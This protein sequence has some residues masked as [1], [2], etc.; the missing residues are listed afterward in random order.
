MFQ[1]P[2]SFEV[3][4][5]M[6]LWSCLWIISALL[7]L[8]GLTFI[9]ILVYSGRY[10][11]SR[12]MRTVQEMPSVSVVVPTFN[13]AATIKK[14]I[15]NTMQLDYP[16]DKLELVIVDCS[17]DA[18]PEIVQS[19]LKTYPQIRLIRESERR[20]LATSLN[21]GYSSSN[22]KVIVKSDCD[23]ITLTKDALKRAV[24]LLENPGLGGVTGTYI[25]ENDVEASFRS[26]EVMQQKAESQI[27]STIVAHGSFMAFRKDLMPT[28][29]PTSTADDTELFMKVR[30]KGDRVVLDTGIRTYEP[31][32][33]AHLRRLGQRSRRAGGIIRVLLGNLDLLVSN[34]GWR[35][36]YV[37][38]PMNLL[39]LVLF[40]WA[41][42]AGVFAVLLAL[43][44][45]SIQLA[46]G[47]LV[48][49]LLALGTYLVG[50]PKAIAGLLDIAVASARGELDL[51]RGKPQYIWEKATIDGS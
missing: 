37:V 30:R 51:L 43:W 26:L 8:Y 25:G 40:P 49:P 44:E 34:V 23:A 7:V 50:R 39:M 27:D 42:L 6:F 29:D 24:S 48:L 21:I 9:T 45:V 19:L 20:G 4:N 32:R 18:T 13:E 33:K 41:L 35:F 38:Y 31:Y 1:K 22:G 14:K 10:D 2:R 16:P 46:I 17:T 36:S 47:G 5:A 15:E 3:I 11:V 28:I 12:L